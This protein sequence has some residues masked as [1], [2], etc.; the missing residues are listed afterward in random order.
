[1]YLYFGFRHFELLADDAKFCF[2]AVSSRSYGAVA[3]RSLRLL[4][5]RL[6]AVAIL[7]NEC[8]LVLVLE[9]RLVYTST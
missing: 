1:M 6:T 7:A 2:N 8:E 5:A 4:T 3:D 9:C